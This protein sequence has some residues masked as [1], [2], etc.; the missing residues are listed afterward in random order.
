[1]ESTRRYTTDAQ[2]IAICA[3]LARQPVYPIHPSAVQVSTWRT[4]PDRATFDAAVERAVEGGFVDRLVD[5][6]IC[7]SAGATG[8]D[9]TY[10][11][12]PRGSS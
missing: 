8:V 11:E 2:V 6:R 3:A 5:G 9:W 1:M 7:L 12:R 4:W 10:L